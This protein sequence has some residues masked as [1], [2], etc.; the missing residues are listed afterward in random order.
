MCPSHELP[1][2]PK[3][4]VVITAAEIQT[5]LHGEPVTLTREGRPVFTLMPIDPDQAWFWTPEWQ[6]KEYEVDR[7]VAAGEKGK[8]FDT[9]EEFLA[10]LKERMKA[11]GDQ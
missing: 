4:D 11:S 5:V 3:K 10:N 6:A 2:D 1:T 7:E 9:G 8:I